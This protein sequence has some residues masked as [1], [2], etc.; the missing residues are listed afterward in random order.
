MRTGGLV[1]KVRTGW[2]R[3]GG[4]K[5]ER[6]G[7]NADTVVAEGGGMKEAKEEGKHGR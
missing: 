6:N 5:N 1:G 7:Q 2:G 4:E 3:K